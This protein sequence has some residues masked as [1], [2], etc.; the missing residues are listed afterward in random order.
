MN[1][2]RVRLNF[3]GLKGT[4][5]RD[6]WLFFMN[7]YRGM[8]EIG[9]V[10]SMELDLQSLFGLLVTWCTQLYSLAETPQPPPPPHLDS[11]TRA[12]LVSQDRR[13]LFMT[14][15]YLPPQLEHTTQLCLWSRDMGWK[16]RAC[17]P[18]P[19]QAG[20]ILPSSWNVSQKVATATLCVYS[21]V[22]TDEG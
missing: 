18:N 6:C 13:H 12:L 15:W 22:R 7:Q 16:G 8:G 11:S 1:S 19:H 21:V 20:M 2:L 3:I 9:G 4:V 17:T 10:L 5:S 14:P